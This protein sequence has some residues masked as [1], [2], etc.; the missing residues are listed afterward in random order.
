[1]KESIKFSKIL[2]DLLHEADCRRAILGKIHPQG[3]RC[4]HCGLALPESKHGRFWA[5][6]I[7]SCRICRKKFSATSKTVLSSM[8]I[9]FSEFFL[10]GILFEL[11]LRRVEVIRRMPFCKDTIARFK[12]RWVNRTI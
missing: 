9:K 2:P 4:P 12:K 8:K 10:M 6:K 5:N 11:G 3:P 1:M 7:C